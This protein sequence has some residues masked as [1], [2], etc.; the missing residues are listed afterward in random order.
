LV[1]FFLGV[2]SNKE[3]E[4]SMRCGA[5]NV[6]SWVVRYKKSKVQALGLAKPIVEGLLPIGCEEDPARG[7]VDLELG[8]EDGEDLLRGQRLGEGVETSEGKS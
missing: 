5:L 8:G 2:A 4:D 1:Q 3:V 6:L 7:H